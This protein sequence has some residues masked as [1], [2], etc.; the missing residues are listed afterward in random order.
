MAKLNIDGKDYDSDELSENALNQLGSLQACEQKITQL[1][2]DLAIVQ[3]AR[4]AYANALMR[5]LPVGES[6][7]DEGADAK[8]DEGADETDK[9]S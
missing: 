5:D 7:V 1:Q 2:A 9:T 6:P 3:T 8:V 4:T